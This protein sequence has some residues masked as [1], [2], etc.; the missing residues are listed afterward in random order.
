MPSPN[1]GVK[2]EFC[3]R[4]SDRLHSGSLLW[5]VCGGPVR[6]CEVREGQPSSKTGQLGGDVV[7]RTKITAELKQRLLEMARQGMTD[8]EIAKLLNVSRSTVCNQRSR[9][10]I[11][12]ATQGDKVGGKLTNAAYERR[13]KL[14]ERGYTDA[15]LS[16][17]LNISKPAVCEWRRSNDLPANTGKMVVKASKMPKPYSWKDAPKG[18]ICG[19]CA[20]W[21]PS[22]PESVKCKQC[23]HREMWE[24]V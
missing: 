23:D 2:S 13:M 21:E 24:A 9:A 16:V 11:P 4:L 8:P 12:L 18:A 7:K 14:Y 6:G 15:A 10:K 17:A 20:H 5:G 19:T 22:K 3:Y 1:G